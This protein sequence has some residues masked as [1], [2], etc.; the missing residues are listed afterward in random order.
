MLNWFSDSRARSVIQTVTQSKHFTSRVRFS[1]VHLCRHPL[2]D[3]Y[4][5]TT[6]QSWLI[7]WQTLGVCITTVGVFVLFLLCIT[8]IATCAGESFSICSEKQWLSASICCASSLMRNAN[9]RDNEALDSRNSSKVYCGEAGM[10]VLLICTQNSA[11]GQSKLRM[12]CEWKNIIAESISKRQALY[13]HN[14]SCNLIMHSDGKHRRHP[15]SS[16]AP[17]GSCLGLANTGSRR[18]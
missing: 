15:I 5:R 16:F 3:A 7:E 13:G 9:T 4:T 18:N 14:V 17:A 6:Q 10:W 12:L 2:C 8:R 11:L 1:R